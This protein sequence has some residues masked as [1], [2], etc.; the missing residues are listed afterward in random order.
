M[1]CQSVTLLLATVVLVS[2]LMTYINC[3]AGF[4]FPHFYGFS[5]LRCRNY[6][7][8]NKLTPFEVSALTSND[9]RFATSKESTRIAESP[10][11][12]SVDHENLT[13]VLSI[14]VDGGATEGAFIATCDF[15]NKVVLLWMLSC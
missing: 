6:N 10:A 12:I 9:H 7:N 1:Y 14:T 13:A 5:N 11:V 8:N 3:V 4:I 15:L 2:M